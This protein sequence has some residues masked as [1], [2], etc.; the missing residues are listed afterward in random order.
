MKKLI[1]NILSSSIV[2]QIESLVDKILA[3]KKANP[4]TDTGAWEKE[5]DELVY[6][7]YELTEEEIKIIENG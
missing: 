4:Q 5:I 1:K 7:L 3:V 2:N 6:E